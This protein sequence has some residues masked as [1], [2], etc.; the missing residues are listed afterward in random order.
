M[1]MLLAR[2][3]NKIVGPEAEEVASIDK[4]LQQDLLQNK[5]LSR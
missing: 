2:K 4:N 5:K 1:A 3:D